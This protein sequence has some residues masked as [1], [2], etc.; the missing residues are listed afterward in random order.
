MAYEAWV[1]ER[2]VKFDTTPGAANV[3]G[4][5]A[6]FPVLIQLDSSNFNFS[7]ADPNGAD[8]RF[9]DSDGTQLSFEIE[10]WD[11]ANQKAIIWVRV[12]QVD[13]NSNQDYIHMH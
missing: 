11:G 1:Y 6:N 4:N 10:R 13:G 8:I 2:K 3:S 12:P 7:Q 5:G 9:A